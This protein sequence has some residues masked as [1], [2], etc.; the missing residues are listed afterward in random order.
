M[1]LKRPPIPR[2]LLPHR[3]RIADIRRDAW[4][5]TAEDAAHQLKF[6]RIDADLTRAADKTDERTSA[7]W[8][9][10]F[11]CR[12]SL[13]VGF[14][15]SPGQIVTWGDRRLTVKAVTPVCEDSLVH[16][17]EVELEGD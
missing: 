10:F 15:F 9:L 17:Y 11:D 13:P 8:L 7:R 1:K 16:H 4:Q 12:N 2:Y 5:N 3:A 6:I 14:T